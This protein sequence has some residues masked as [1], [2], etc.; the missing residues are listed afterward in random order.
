M[1]L[2]INKLNLPT[3]AFVL[4]SNLCFAQ[5]DTDRLLIRNQ[6]NSKVLNELESD[7]ETISKK[8][9]QRAIEFAEENKIP[10]RYIDI[11]GHLNE[12]QFLGPN[13]TPIYY[14]SFNNCVHSLF[15]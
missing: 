11:K 9:K 6:Y 7:N 2:K 13:N 15:C 10:T 14:K 5:N 3:L 4:I 12:I 1:V 8:K